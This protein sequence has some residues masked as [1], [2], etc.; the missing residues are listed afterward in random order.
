MKVYTGEKPFDCD[1]S[2]KSF[3]YKSHINKHMRIHTGENCFICHQCGK[4]FSHRANFDN[5]MIVHTRSLS[6]A[7]SVERA[8]QLKETYSHQSSHWREALQ[9]SS[10]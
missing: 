7:L 6:P 4:S 3:E 2:G 5:H 10:V 9:V 1:Q 8:L